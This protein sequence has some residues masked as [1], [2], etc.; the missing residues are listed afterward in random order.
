MSDD[1]PPEYTTKQLPKPTE[2][3]ILLRELKVGQENGFRQ[4]NGSLDLVAADVR[5]A[6]RRL[7]EVD[8]WR[9]AVDE[10]ASKN[11]L[12]V[13]ENSQQD[14]EQDA[15]LA[16]AIQRQ[17]KLEKDAAEAKAAAEA[18]LTETRAQTKILTDL[19]K[20]PWVIKVAKGLAIAL[21]TYLATKGVHLP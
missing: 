10:R 18:V 19:A 4:V 2:A 1:K 14:L 9:A 3:E 8:E 5:R 20:N 13:K 21:L 11:S 15:R 6:H 7:D 17:E 16:Q 12:R